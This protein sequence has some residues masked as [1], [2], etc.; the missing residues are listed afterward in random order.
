M[1]EAP[2]SRLAVPGT[3][4]RV[5]AR[6]GAR[7]N[8]V[9]E[10]EAGLSVETTEAAEG[11]RANAAILRLLGKALGVAPGRLTL[12]RGATAR[13]KLIRLD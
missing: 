13:Q 7:R 8:L 3:V 11:G 6:P 12:L 2:L 1:A 9:T 10:A 5:R 4:L